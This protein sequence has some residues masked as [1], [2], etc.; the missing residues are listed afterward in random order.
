MQPDDGRQVSRPPAKQ[1]NCQRERERAQGK[2][3]LLTSSGRLSQPPEHRLALLMSQTVN[4][5]NSYV[6]PASNRVSV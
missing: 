4:Q 6:R 3:R 1:V 2:G 5:Y